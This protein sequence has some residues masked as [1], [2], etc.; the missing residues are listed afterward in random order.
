MA[1]IS[2][3]KKEKKQSFYL[4]FIS[5]SQVKVSPKKYISVELT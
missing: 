5:K 3:K 1:K 2:G 4:G